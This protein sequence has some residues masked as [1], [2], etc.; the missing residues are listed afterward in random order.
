MNDFAEL[1]VLLTGRSASYRE[2]AAH[3]GVEQTFAENAL[4]DHSGGSEQ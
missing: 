2:D 3:F 1:G 4:P